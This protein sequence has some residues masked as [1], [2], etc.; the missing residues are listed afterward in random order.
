MVYLYINYITKSAYIVIVQLC[1]AGF[2]QSNHCLILITYIAALYLIFSNAVVPE[3]GNYWS[4]KCV[5][6]NKNVFKMRQTI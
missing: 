2:N 1:D 3:K 4:G 6:L 5:L